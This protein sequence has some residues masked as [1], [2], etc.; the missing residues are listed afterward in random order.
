[1]RLRR[2]RSI[3]VT[4]PPAVNRR[5][6]GKPA[7]EAVPV[8]L[9][10]VLAGAVSR[11]LGDRLLVLAAVDVDVALGLHLGGVLLGERRVDQLLLEAGL[12]EADE[13]VVGPDIDRL[14]R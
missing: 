9:P 12:Q 11:A 5:S 2:A 13:I 6:R 8:S 3:V 14:R 4:R 7:S 10:S 1:V